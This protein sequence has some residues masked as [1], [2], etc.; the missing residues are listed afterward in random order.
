RTVER[1]RGRRRAVTVEVGDD[2]A[3][4]LGRQQ[5]GDGQADALGTTGDDRRLPLQQTAHFRCPFMLALGAACATNAGTISVS[6]AGS[7]WRPASTVGPLTQPS[8]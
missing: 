4:A 6:S 5:S 1:G 3:R 8:F 7:H 2:D